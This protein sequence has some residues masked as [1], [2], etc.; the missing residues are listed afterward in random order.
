MQEIRVIENQTIGNVRI[1]SQAKAPLAP[2]A[3]NRK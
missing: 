3:S 2:I 1:V